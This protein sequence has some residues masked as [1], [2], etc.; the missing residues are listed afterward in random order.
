MG[1]GASWWRGA[2]WVRRYRG[3]RG[4][5]EVESASRRSVDCA[6]HATRPNTAFGRRYLALTSEKPRTV[7]ATGHEYGV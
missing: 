4:K 3:W 6:A 2:G 1:G 7:L 5:R